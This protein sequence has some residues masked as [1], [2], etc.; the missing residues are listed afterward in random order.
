MRSN[1]SDSNSSSDSDDAVA[2]GGWRGARRAGHGR[3]GWQQHPATGD[4]PEAAAGGQP[5][6]VGSLTAGW[7]E[8]DDADSLAD[9]GSERAGGGGG[10]G[11]LS[12]GGSS[13]G[14]S[15]SNDDDNDEDEKLCGA[16]DDSG[17]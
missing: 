9:D 2:A 14:G 15:G 17:F 5:R 13:R 11:M 8:A 10:G 6:V 1:H 12:A 3:G 16:S 7:D 4:A